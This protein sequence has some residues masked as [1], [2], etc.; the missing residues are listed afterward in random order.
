MFN[1]NVIGDYITKLE[2]E[3]KFL[4]ERNKD[5]RQKT[6]YSVYEENLELKQQLE[7]LKY[8]VAENCELR[9]QVELFNDLFEDAR[10]ASNYF[11][12]ENKRLKDAIAS[13]QTFTKQF[14]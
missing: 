10:T 4:K 13:V 1:H 9:E 12:E 14:T 6:W 8:A 3:N 11:I 2:N 7:K 5:L